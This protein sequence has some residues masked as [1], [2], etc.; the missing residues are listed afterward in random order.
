MA[1]FVGKVVANAAYLIPENIETLPFEYVELIQ[2]ANTFLDASPQNCNVLKI[3][4]K[5]KK[6]SFLEYDD[7]HK[8]PFPTL[9]QSISVDLVKEAI[10][11]RSYRTR[12][13][14]PI[15]HRKELLL[16]E[17][18]PDFEKFSLLTRTLEELGLFGE[19]SRIGTKQEWS[20]LLNSLGV[21]IDDHRVI[22]SEKKSIDET[23]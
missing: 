16:G 1:N 2:R 6:V 21:R 4:P 8:E 19:T 12:D 13:N 15:L 11:H 20:E 7:I 10:T 22:C 3:S 5:I 23:I 14:P 9:R 17:E 18:H